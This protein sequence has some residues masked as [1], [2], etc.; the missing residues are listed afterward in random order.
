MA[1]RLPN[2]A[3]YEVD[4]TRWRDAAA[5]GTAMVAV[6]AAKW[7]FFMASLLDER[8]VWLGLVGAAQRGRPVLQAGPSLGTGLRGTET[9]KHF[10]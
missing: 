8:G 7:L 10:P 4:S 9:A 5:T 6:G 3:A 1:A 2:A